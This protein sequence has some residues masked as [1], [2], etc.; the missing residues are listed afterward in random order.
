MQH[1]AWTVLGW[2]TTYELLVLLAH[3]G[4]DYHDAQMQVGS[5]K[6]MQVSEGGGEKCQGVYSSSGDRQRLTQ[7]CTLHRVRSYLYPAGHT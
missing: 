2:E 6:S 1:R 4:S 5:F 3:M 7:R